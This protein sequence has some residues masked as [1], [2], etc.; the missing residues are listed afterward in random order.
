MEDVLFIYSNSIITENSE[1]EILEY[2]PADL[3]GLDRKLGLGLYP[4][5][6]EL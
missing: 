3:S 1:G 2:L 4:E 6:R 5:N